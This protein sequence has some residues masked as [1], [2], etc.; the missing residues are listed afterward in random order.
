MLSARLP[1][2]S[3]APQLTYGGGADITPYTALETTVTI[4][5]SSLGPLLFGTLVD[6]GRTIVQEVCGADNLEKEK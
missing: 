2:L 3:P 5:V 6:V 1:S 4:V